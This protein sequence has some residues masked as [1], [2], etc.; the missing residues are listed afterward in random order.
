MSRIDTSLGPVFSGNAV[1]LYKYEPFSGNVFTL[2][3][4]APSGDVIAYTGSLELD[5]FLT[6]FDSSRS[7]LF[8]STN[9]PTTSASNLSFSIL[10]LSGSITMAS[11][12][13]TVNIG[14]GR[15]LQPP[16]G[17]SFDFYRNEPLG[18]NYLF[19]G[20]I[21][22]SKP[23]S[24]V[25]LPAGLSFVQNDVCSYFLTGT[26][27]G[28][29]PS[30]N[31]TIYATG[32]PPNQSRLISVQPSIRV[33][34][35]RLVLD[36]SGIGISSNATV[37]TSITPIL[38][39]G[40]CPPYTGVGGSYPGNNIRYT[41]T[42]SLPAGLFFTDI[43]GNPLTTG[44][45]PTDTSST[46]ILQG[47]I[48][49][50]GIQTLSSSNLD[51]T[52]TGTR[53]SFPAI[54]NS[55][56]LRVVFDETV[57]F[58][59]L[60]LTPIYKDATIPRTFNN[61]FFARTL[62][63][64]VDGSIN[65]ISSTNL[66][67]GVTLDFSFNA[68]RAFLVGTPDTSGFYTSTIRATNNN[69]VFSDIT[70]NIS[71]LADS[72]TFTSVPSDVCSSFIIGRALSN[73]K[74]GYYNAPLRFTAQSAS[75][76]NVTMNIPIL[77]LSGTGI[78]FDTDASGGT[79]TYTLGGSPINT[80]GITNT[81]VTAT[82]LDT[83][84]SAVTPFRFQ[85]LQDQFTF[86]DLSLNLI[87]NVP[88]TSTP[89][90]VTTLS[91][92]NVLWYISSNLPS[93][94][95]I[96]TTGIIQG[97]P[98]GSTNGVF[99]IVVSTGL[100]T[101]TS[102]NFPYYITPDS[103]LLF[104]AQPSYIY[105]AGANVS[106]PITGLSYSGNTVSNYLLSNFPTP[107]ITIGST[108][109]LISGTLTDGIPPN[110]VF[111]VGITVFDI[112]G[113]VGLS[114]G[115]LPGTFTTTNP[116]VE[117]SFL[118]TNRTDDGTLPYTRLFVSDISDYLLDW[119]QARVNYSL[120]NTPLEI[121]NQQVSAIGVGYLN[122]INAIVLA[123]TTD[124]RGRIVRSTDGFSFSDIFYFPVGSPN[125]VVFSSLAQ[126]S[127]IYTWYLAGA[128]DSNTPAVLVRSADGGLTWSSRVTIEDMGGNQLF[129]RDKD[130]LVSPPAGVN[131]YVYRGTALAYVN[132]TIVAGGRGNTINTMF[133]STD[134]GSNWSLPSGNVLK[135]EVS[136]FFVAED[137][138]AATGS[139]LYTTQNFEAYTTPAQTII[140][141]DDY[142]NTWNL[143]D[144]FQ[145]TYLDSSGCFNYMGYDIVYANGIAI[146]SGISY[147]TTGDGAPQDGYYPEV[148]VSSNATEWY[149]VSLFD[150]FL[151]PIVSFADYIYPI[152]IGP[153]LYDASAGWNMIVASNAGGGSYFSTLFNV[154]NPAF[155]SIS[156]VLSNWV[157]LGALGGS[158]PVSTG[159]PYHTGLTLK[160][161]FGQ[162]GGQLQALIQFSNSTLGGPVFTSPTQ[163]TYTVYQY[164]PITPITFSAVGTGVVYLF[165][166]SATLPTGL[167]W[168]PVTQKIQGKTVNLQT[169]TFTVYAKDDVGITS[170]SISI[171]TIVPRVIRQ[172]SSAGAYTYLV[173]QYTEVNAAQNARDSRVL[174]S[175]ESSLG[176]FMA[177]PAPNVITASNDCCPK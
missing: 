33:N 97:T 161:F 45:I 90:N 112:C 135:A 166:D 151:D 120:S 82:V 139:E 154:P 144:P 131:A 113:S 63:A 117:R 4:G 123:T 62:F 149:K 16:V 78:T 99:T 5:G 13:Y 61:S 48:T 64:T 69:A 104:S 160:N 52:L 137:R 157:N 76:C 19:V 75:G 24:T 91:G 26:P 49:N 147:Y 31:Y 1:Q 141:S 7:I 130:T 65:D 74:T 134:E 127:N 25:S 20:S 77:D 175:Q 92:R 101:T 168:N 89:V 159:L 171:T 60:N 29:T 174:P 150:S 10:D 17:T 66:P 53:V 35:E 129:P 36:I 125:Q 119:T 164:A 55:K 44:S 155:G 136:R 121:S 162:G 106:I 142:G 67:S 68:Q 173:K 83:S 39:S 107:G 51:I 54:S 103:I 12:N 148:R 15:F 23:V 42:P 145:G 71:V 170:L 2:G 116:L 158:I 93:D 87:Q 27:I 133:I 37:D 111:P 132:S 163:T 73:A 41:W 156:D 167:T 56:S 11:C 105:A 8:S 59:N 124:T 122:A 28:Q 95:T 21:P 3:S 22:I 46:I 57:V 94:L 108:T 177:P 32:A 58:S 88:M 18:N 128:Q 169:A 114:S 126:G 176:K 43:N 102:S 84:V 152:Q 40:R 96:T 81:T 143:V 98:R 38:V 50:A 153:V 80:K 85:I 79:V 140:F 118:F 115:K 146:A 172:Q 47:A 72:V 34:A 109:G 100:S 30:S 14:A 9:G 70:A 165:V 6:I 110:P 138:I 86:Q